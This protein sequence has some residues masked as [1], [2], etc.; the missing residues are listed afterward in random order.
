M[1][2]SPCHRFYGGRK[3]AFAMQVTEDG[4]LRT[5][6]TR[7]TTFLVGISLR[8]KDQSPTKV[9]QSGAVF[10]IGWGV[11]KGESCRRRSGYSLLDRTLRL[12]PRSALEEPSYFS[13]IAPFR[14]SR[15]KA[16]TLHESLPPTGRNFGL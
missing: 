8:M 16:C 6:S 7:A 13:S 12:G 1:A 3:R 11:S 15:R 2:R 5:V 10:R 9:G 4:R 14:C